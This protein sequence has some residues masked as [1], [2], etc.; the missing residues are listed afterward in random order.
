MVVQFTEEEKEYV[1]D[2]F[3]ADFKGVWHIPEGQKFMSIDVFD[4]YKHDGSGQSVFY[5]VRE[6]HKVRKR[7]NLLDC[8]KYIHKWL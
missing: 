3:N 7:G 4:L 5:I 2:V 6:D 8:L 1:D